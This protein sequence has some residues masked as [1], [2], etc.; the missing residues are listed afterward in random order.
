MTCSARK[1]TGRPTPM[2]MSNPR[3]C[4]RSSI[5]WL[6]V[7]GVSGAPG[8][9][10]QLAWTRA[11]AAS[12]GHE[13]PALCGVVSAFFAGLGAG[14]GLLDGRVSRSRHPVR[15]YAGLE[16]FSAAWIA[17]GV[18]RCHD[19]SDRIATAGRP[20]ERRTAPEPSGIAVERTT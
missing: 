9:I 10:A 19:G 13:G 2:P 14:A 11:F 12:L 8:L 18:G 17:G 3:A 7:F 20:G 6:V 16:A 4:R 1:E 5:L 15:W